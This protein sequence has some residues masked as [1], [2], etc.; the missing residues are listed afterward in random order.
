M[1]SSYTELE[2]EKIERDQADEVK[3]LQENA[4]EKVRALLAGHQSKV[5]QS[6]ANGEEITHSLRAM[7]PVLLCSLRGTPCLYQGEELGLEEAELGFEDLRDPYGITFWPTYKGRDGCRTPMPWSGGLPNAGFSTGKPWL[8]VSAS[9]LPLAVDQQAADERSVLNVTRAFLNWRRERHPLRLAPRERP[10]PAPRQVPDPEPHQQRLG[11]HRPLRPRDVLHPVL[12]VAERRQVREQREPLEHVRQPP[13]VHRHL[14][15]ER[16]VEPHLAG[17]NA[18]NCFEDHLGR[19]RLVQ[20][21]ASAGQHG[22]LVH[23]RVASAGKDQN[24]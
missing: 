20:Y 24:L 4:L 3:I 22:A 10:R 7:L 17:V 21:A 2:I 5:K 23:L 1:R 18:V 9:H 6:L 13:L 19:F 11:L 16:P 14:H 8:P 12:D 15:P